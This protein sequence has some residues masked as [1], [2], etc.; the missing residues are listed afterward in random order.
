M[1]TLV[2]K[3]KI[4]KIKFHLKFL[5]F[6]NGVTKSLKIPQSRSLQMLLKWRISCIFSCAFLDTRHTDQTLRNNH[7]ELTPWT[8]LN[9]IVAKHHEKKK[10]NNIKSLVNLLLTKMFCD[11]M[12]Q[13]TTAWKIHVFPPVAS[14]LKYSRSFKWMSLQISPASPVQRFC[15][16]SWRIRVDRS[17]RDNLK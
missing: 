17:H 12:I 15:I 11:K 9:H 14:C 4:G 1:G 5:R 3:I 7:V 10:K 16:A 2:F 8:S 13:K 6:K